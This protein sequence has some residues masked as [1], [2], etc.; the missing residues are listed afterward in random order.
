MAK[1]FL[2]NTKVGSSSE[3]VGSEAMPEKVG[4][5]IGFETC[6][7]GVAFDE[8][9]DPLWRQLPAAHGE[10]DFGSAAP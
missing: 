2:N 5:H 1:H 7:R 9:P 4:I 10:K 8:L 6:A 3:Q